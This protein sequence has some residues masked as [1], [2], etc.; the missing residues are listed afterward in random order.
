MQKKKDGCIIIFL[1]TLNVEI[2]TIFEVK[3]M[4]AAKTVRRP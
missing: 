2:N 3:T 1:S 4:L